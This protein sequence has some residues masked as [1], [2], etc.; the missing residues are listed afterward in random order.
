MRGRTYKDS[1][2]HLAREPQASRTRKG[3]GMIKEEKKL[4]DAE[5]KRLETK[6]TSACLVDKPRMTRQDT[7]DHTTTL[8]DCR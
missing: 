8:E 7:D 6:I 5:I 3:P 4:M 2:N 1:G